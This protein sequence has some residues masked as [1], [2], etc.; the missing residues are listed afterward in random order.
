MSDEITEPPENLYQVIEREVARLLKAQQVC[1]HTAYGGMEK[2]G[3][4]C[5]VCGKFMVDFGD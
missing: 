2:H 5:P 3:R 4:C 1:D